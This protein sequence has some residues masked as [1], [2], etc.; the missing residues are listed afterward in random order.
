MILEILLD[1]GTGLVRPVVV[2]AT[3]V[4]V[5]QDN[6]TPIAVAAEYGPPGSQVVAKAGDP[7][8][9]AELRKVGVREPV[10]CD[11]LELP[12]PPPGARLVAG[13]RFPAT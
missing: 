1:D 10:A 8:F 7:E 11:L 5:R 12:K 6:G 2:A 3:R 4:V 13:P 9:A